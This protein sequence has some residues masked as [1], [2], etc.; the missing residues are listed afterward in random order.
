MNPALDR[1]ELFGC[2]NKLPS[3][4]DTTAS[5]HISGRS[6]NLLYKKTDSSPPHFVN[7]SG[8]FV[9][10]SG[11][12]LHIYIDIYVWFSTNAKDILLVF[13]SAKLWCNLTWHGF[14]KKHVSLHYTTKISKTKNHTRWW[15][16]PLWKSESNWKSSPNRCENR[17]YLK[18]TPPLKIGHAKTKLVFQ[19]SIFRCC[20]SFRE[21]IRFWWGPIKRPPPSRRLFLQYL[22]QQGLSAASGERKSIT[23]RCIV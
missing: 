10:I 21:G 11:C 6:I 8:Y 17:Q 12:E 4:Y 1:T 16:Q 5:F 15:F 20:V 23:C 9:K 3:E 18:K 22:R 7:I 13:P 14:Q 2:W 19:P